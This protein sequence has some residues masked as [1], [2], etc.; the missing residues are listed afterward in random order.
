MVVHMPAKVIIVMSPK[1]GVG[2]TTAAVNLATAISS[3]GRKTLLVDA[4]LETPHVAVY[5]GFVG[6]KYSLEDVLNGATDL[7]NAIYAGDNPNF[8]L[9]PARV[10]KKAADRS[11]HRLVN[12]NL[13]L[14]KIEDLYDF[15]VIDSKPSYDIDFIKLIKNANGLIVSNPDITS[16]IEAKKLKEEMADAAIPVMGL[17]I[18]RINGRIKEQM[19]VKEIKELTGI[20]NTWKIREDN[21][22]YRA[23]KEGIPIVMSSPKSRASRDIMDISKEITRL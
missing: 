2:K 23:L 4:N 5:Y 17:I 15:I 22:V 21:G 20:K 7:K 13:Y 3:L 11:S 9:L 1:G 19:D 10:S 8:N 6:F 14:K 18:N 16:V 12:I